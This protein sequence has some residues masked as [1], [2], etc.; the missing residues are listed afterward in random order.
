M[1]GINFEGLRR[2]QTY[3]EVVD[4]LQNDRET[5]KYPDRSAKFLRESPEIM[6]LLDG[7]GIGYD[8]LVDQQKRALIQQKVKTIE[9]EKAEEQQTTTAHVRAATRQ[10]RS[11]SDVSMNDWGSAYEEFIQ[12]IEMDQQDAEQLSKERIKQMIN[13]VQ[14]DLGATSVS[15]AQQMASAAAA[16]SSTQL[17]L[18]YGPPIP[19]PMAV[20]LEGK[21]PEKRGPEDEVEP[22]GRPGRPKLVLP[23]ITPI[24]VDPEDKKRLRD[25]KPEDVSKSKKVKEQQVKELLALTDIPRAELLK[26]TDE[27]RTELLKLTDKPANVIITGDMIRKIA[28]VDLALRAAKEAQTIRQNPTPKINTNLT[29][30]SDDVKKRIENMRG[31]TGG[32]GDDSPTRRIRAKQTIGKDKGDESP[33]RSSTNRQG[34]TP[35]D[36]D[37]DNRKRTYWYNQ[38]VGYVTAQL[39]AH[40]IKLTEGELTGSIKHRNKKGEVIREEKVHRLTKPEKLERLFAHLGI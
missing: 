36:T 25:T 3:D 31:D 35:K 19:A 26:L 17:P 10:S 13:E 22:R 4:Y 37:P 2:R 7:E 8:A 29:Q 39:D 12:D 32:T 21:G 20:D 6:N 16:S 40:G 27:Q 28:D 38:S 1:Y 30:V 34:G 24:E 5:V 33:T 9:L 15:F 11:P 23:T 14:Q 18:I